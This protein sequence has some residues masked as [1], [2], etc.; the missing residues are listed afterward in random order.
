[1]LS[2][3]RRIDKSLIKEVLQKGKRYNSPTFT[4]Y[5]Y[6]PTGKESGKTSQFA[7]TASK[8][9]A[10]LAVDRNRLRRIG[11]SIIDKNIS[12]IKDGS[13]FLFAYKKILGKPTLSIIETEALRLLGEASMLK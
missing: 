12:K 10:A 1:M 3:E 5:V 13:M 4:L 11:Y 6:D 8:K 2:K 7:F 9:V